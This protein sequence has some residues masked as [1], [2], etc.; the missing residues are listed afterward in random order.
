MNITT[1]VSRYIILSMLALSVVGCGEPCLP[2]ILADT[3]IIPAEQVCDGSTGNGT[4]TTS[5]TGAMNATDDMCPVPPIDAFVCPAV[6]EVGT[7]WGPCAE[8]LSCA[9]GSMCIISP[10]IG[11]VC[12]P[13]CDDCG[14]PNLGCFGGTC[15]ADN[16][17][18]PTC[19]AV[20]DPCPVPVMQCAPDA[21]ACVW[22]SAVEK[23]N[24][25]NVGEVWWP[26][27]NGACSDGSACVDSGTA[28]ICAPVCEGDACGAD[29]F[30]CESEAANTPTCGTATTCHYDC[31]AIT[32]CAQGQVC[33]ANL[34]Q[35][36]WPK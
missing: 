22:P 16:A 19:V 23:C 25:I 31:T 21:G 12:A 35:C 15:N 4:S 18:A 1:N 2:T 8:D 9:P 26:C 28:W 29:P 36:M 6:P 17:C 7:M 27:D 34:G 3:S 14:C 32:E 24:G 11:N 30:A 33:D 5:I 10:N 20:G 13:Q